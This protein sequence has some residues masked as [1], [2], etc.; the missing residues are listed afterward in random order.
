MWRRIK[1]T[2]C[3]VCVMTLLAYAGC[4]SPGEEEEAEPCVIENFEAASTCDFDPTKEGPTVGFSAG[5]FCLSGQPEGDF[6]LHEFCGSTD[7]VWLILSTAWCIPCQEHAPYI[8]EVYQAYKE[9]GLVV[10]W[11]MGETLDY[12]PPTQYSVDKFIEARGVTFPV[13]FD[14]RFKK[15]YEKLEPQGSSL[16]HMY[17]LDGQTMEMLA[18]QTSLGFPIEQIIVDHYE[19]PAPLE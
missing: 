2:G 7:M 9:Q 13:F 11:V 17:L 6:W 15:V 19:E 10:V 4:S 12:A 16:P 5:N 8:N 1:T 14:Y 18:R 3:I